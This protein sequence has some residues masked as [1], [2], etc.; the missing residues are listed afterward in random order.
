MSIG[1]SKGSQL[2]QVYSF[3]EALPTPHTPYPMPHSRCKVN[4]AINY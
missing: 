3:S 4:R 1:L 2:L